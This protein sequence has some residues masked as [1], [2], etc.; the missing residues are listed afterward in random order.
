MA[1]E[2]TLSLIMVNIIVFL[3]V[4]SAP[5][6]QQKWIFETFYFSAGTA[7]QIWRWLTSIFLHANASH[8]FFNILGL[9]FFGRILEEEMPRPWFLAIYFISGFLGNL[10]FMLTNSAPIVGASG[11]VFGLMGAAMFLNPVKRINLYIIPLPLGIVALMFVIVETLVVYF[12]PEFGNIAHI[13]HI[14]GVL[15]GG[16]FAFFFDPKRSTKGIL[17]LII[18]VLLLILLGPLFALITGIGG[19]ILQ[20]IDAVVGFFLYGLANLLSFIWG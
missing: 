11:A 16:I 1:N 19:F 13:A 2:L 15:T 20:I 12:Q 6:P 4:F 5:E 17:V 3:L 10:A 7:T 8:L 14:G 9:Y 18:S